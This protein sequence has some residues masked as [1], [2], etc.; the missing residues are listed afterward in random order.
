[1]RIHP[2]TR[3]ATVLCRTTFA[4]VLLCCVPAAFAFKLSPMVIE[5]APSGKGATQVFTV[6]N[7]GRNKVALS[8]EMTT[9]A[10][11]LKGKEAREKTADFVIYPE[12]FALEAN[13]RRNVRVTY[14]GK[15]SPAQELGY[16]FIATQLPIGF[17]QETGGGRLKFLLQY[18]AAVYVT[19]KDAHPE[20]FLESASLTA[21]DELTLVLGNRGT[22]HKNLYDMRLELRAGEGA[23][24]QPL[25]LTDKSRE[26]LMAE[27]LLPGERREVVLKLQEKTA[28]SG[29]LGASIH[30]P[31]PSP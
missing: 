27:N 16:R 14:T 30:F 31:Q 25:S 21:P 5:F 18:V 11:D 29:K 24:S 2:L 4:L 12:Q 1:M 3:F 22:A 10:H 20:V 6:E 8:F 19:P 17:E 9:R 28:V 13:D 15:G 23:M 26:A 7:N